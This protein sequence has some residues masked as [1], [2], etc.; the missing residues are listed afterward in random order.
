MFVMDKVA[1][2]IA[3][4]LAKKASAYAVVRYYGFPRVYRRFCE[5]NKRITDNKSIILRRQNIMK[6]CIRL[7]GRIFSFWSSKPARKL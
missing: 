3:L 1:A 6:Y 4:A 7:P 5:F 2:I